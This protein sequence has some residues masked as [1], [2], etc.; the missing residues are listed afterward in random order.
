[1]FRALV[2][3]CRCGFINTKAACIY[4]DPSNIFYVN[5]HKLTHLKTTVIFSRFN[6]SLPPF[7]SWVLVHWRGL[8]YVN[9]SCRVRA[10]LLRSQSWHNSW[11][12]L[13]CWSQCS[14]LCGRKSRIIK[15]ILKEEISCYAIVWKILDKH[16]IVILNSL[17]CIKLYNSSLSYLI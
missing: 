10:H 2:K 14:D 16:T 8:L 17:H 15:I 3:G 11:R 7:S 6:M 1:M 12:N 4:A 5:P 13:H 9:F